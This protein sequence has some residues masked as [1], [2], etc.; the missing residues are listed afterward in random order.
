[1][2]DNTSIPEPA[3]G[4]RAGPG[5]DAVTGWGVPDGIKLMNVL[6]AI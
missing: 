3:K 6:A 2:G 4:Y 1:M 5:Y